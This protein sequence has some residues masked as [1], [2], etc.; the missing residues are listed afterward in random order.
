VE[1]NLGEFYDLKQDPK[2]YASALGLSNI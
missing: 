1:Y 2:R